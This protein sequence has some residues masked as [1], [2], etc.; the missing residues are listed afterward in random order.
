VGG[1]KCQFV[2]F[3]AATTPTPTSA[4]DSKAEAKGEGKLVGTWK[5]VS[6][7]NQEGK[8]V[9]I[10]QGT[11]VLKLLTPTH[12][13]AVTHNADGEV[14]RASGGSYT[15]KGDTFEEVPEF[16]ISSTYDLE[17][18]KGKPQSFRCKIVGNKW[19]HSGTLSNGG[20]IDEEWERVEKDQ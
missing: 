17:R 16:A 19:Y 10:P 15:L 2:A 18:L 5:L 9:E 1:P 12:F 14:S 13:I 11:R 8:E 4:D 7:K 3:V 6:K 20:T